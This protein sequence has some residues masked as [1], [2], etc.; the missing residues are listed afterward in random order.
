MDDDIA[1]LIREHRIADAAA[2]A[3][4]RGDAITASALFERACE[5]HLAASEALRANDAARAMRL[6]VLSRDG[7][8]IERAL[9]TLVAAPSAAEPVAAALEAHGDHAWAA[10]IFEAVGR[11]AEAARAWDRAGNAVRAA[12]LLE[13]AH[14]VVGAARVLETAIRRAPLHWPNQLALGGLLV[15]YGKAQAA[16][17]TLQGI[18]PDAAERLP[19][20]HLLVRA[21]EQLGLEQAAAEAKRELVAMGGAPASEEPAAPIRASRPPTTRIYGRYEVAREI[22]STP[23]SRVL[24][25]IDTVR[26]ERVAIKIYA[27][28]SARG[29]GRDVL[30]RFERE[31]R[32]LASLDHPNVVPL[33]DYFPDGPALVLAWMPGGTLEEMLARGP[34][35]PARAVEI[36][37]ALLGALEEA[38]RVG[39][40]HRDIK[41]SNVLFDG[42]GTAR[43]A[44]FG[45]AHLGDLSATATAGVIG[46]LSYM[47]PEQRAGEPASLASD[48]YGVGA[49]LLEMLTG[50]RAGER[51]PHGSDTARRPSAS[52]RDLDTRHDAVVHAL[53]AHEPARRPSDAR[54]ARRALTALPWPAWFATSAPRPSAPSEGVRRR[55]TELEEASARVHAGAPGQPDVDAWLE[56]PILRV[57]LDP[58]TL[59]RA[60]AF[61]RADHPAL[62]IVYR[63]DRRASEIWLDADDRPLD[64]WL[65]DDDRT[66]LTSA[67]EAL[68]RAGI[69]HGNIHRTHVRVGPS[70]H[71][72][73]RFAPP[74]S[75]DAREPH[76]ATADHDREALLRLV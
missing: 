41:P 57:P 16:A 1:R 15:R 33:R 40:L 29:A 74:A 65:T 19:A 42:A 70:G 52:H 46:T 21:L 24:E 69:V 68:H 13:A 26:G 30:A 56:R 71:V 75:P 12:E 6:A 60:S 9:A 18:P 49:V 63:V 73:L 61:A 22:A 5:W 8:L 48:L 45:A 55:S 51:S 2:L 27:G 20:L 47:S 76:V 43:L 14:D 50:E 36:A 64:R 38:H 44:D 17:R 35:A 4:A 59:A 23:S 53:V 39:V 66:R 54:S 28:Y 62:Q 37:C 32:V 25:C 7:A 67:L 10:R 31:L 34:I 3:S 11:S 58:T 72:I